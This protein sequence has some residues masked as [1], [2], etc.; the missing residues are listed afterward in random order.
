L[1]QIDAHGDRPCAP[2]SNSS[3]HR[4][5]SFA[6]PFALSQPLIGKAYHDF[7]VGVPV[8]FSIKAFLAM[9]AILAKPFV[10]MGIVNVTPD[11]FF[12][13]GN[14]A[15]PDDAVRHA[16]ALVAD[17]ADIID[18][19]GESTRP[20]SYP[21]SAEQECERIVPVVE[22]LARSIAVPISVDTS[23]A[24]VARQSFAVGARWINDIS[25]G[26]F[27]ANMPRCAAELGC[28]IVLMHSRNTPADMQVRPQ[29]NDVIAEIK[30]ELLAR[31]K[32]F[33]PAGVSRDNVILDP[34]IGFAKRAED[35]LTVLRR[36]GELTALGFPVLVGASRK[37]FVGQ[38]TG[39]NKEDRLAGSL[40]AV[41]AAS[42]SGARIFRVHDVKETV[43]VLKTLH[44]IVTA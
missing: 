34:G 26:R 15:A 18:I 33:E 43:D 9:D 13:G 31:V 30:D 41:A 11:S 42:Q 44:A 25:A 37:S 24:E 29:Y 40:A 32:V 1:R 10:V 6:T 23:K 39:R 17:G 38:I 14:Y 8:H 4:R 7:L 35:N 5:A 12:D 16:V 28:P 27:D 21:V 3:K 22:A 36:L 2:I 19:G 20:G